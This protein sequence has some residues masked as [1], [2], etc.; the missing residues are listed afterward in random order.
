MHVYN[1]M[2]QIFSGVPIDWAWNLSTGFGPK[3]R[4]QSEYEWAL[5]CW[6][7]K[8]GMP[9]GAQAL[10]I[11]SLDLYSVKEHGV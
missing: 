10:W 6:I 7:L 4:D 5:Q 1:F 9:M 3:S 2:Q 11:L 8:L